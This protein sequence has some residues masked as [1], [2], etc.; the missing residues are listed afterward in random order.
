MHET[1]KFLFSKYYSLFGTTLVVLAIVK[2]LPRLIYFYNLNQTT[3]FLLI[4]A[5]D[6]YIFGLF[7]YFLKR[8]LLPLIKGEAALEINEKGIISKMRNINLQWDKIK[9]VRYYSGRWSNF[10]AIDL[11]NGEEYKLQ[12]Q[13]PFK[14]ITMWINSRFYLTPLIL[15]TIAIQGNDK[16]IFQTIKSYLYQVKNYN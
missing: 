14:K 7:L 2:T 13:N 4:A 1:I 12:F 15:P 6:L 9:D 16:E 5:F 8:Y 3:N 11:V 10:I